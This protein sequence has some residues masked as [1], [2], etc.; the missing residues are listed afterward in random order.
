MVGDQNE[1][2]MI[3]SM[4]ASIT[5]RFTPPFLFCVTNLII[6]ILFMASKS[7]TKST[8]TTYHE[9]Q[10]HQEHDHE[11]EHVRG[12]VLLIKP[13][14]ARVTL[15]LERAKS[16]DLK[17]IIIPIIPIKLSSLPKLPKYTS[18]S[19]LAQ[20]IFSACSYDSQP[21]SPRY[22][23][24][25]LPK[26]L[27]PISGR[28][29]STDFSTIY[30]D[31]NVIVSTELQYISNSPLVHARVNSTKI[32]TPRKS[33]P[34]TL[35]DLD[36]HHVIRHNSE[37]TRKKKDMVEIIKTS[38]SEIRKLVW[39][40]DRVEIMKRPETARARQNAADDAKANDFITKFRGQLKLQ[41][42][43]SLNRYNDMLCRP[44]E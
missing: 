8:T 32:R 9:E 2:M 13:V 1:S 44:I 18:S 17:S 5:T 39:D 23:S 31:N 29:N 43:D 14:V 11:R 4:W 28:L 37:K 24:K 6:A 19:R 3:V 35:V 36:D 38:R 41:R 10:E 30:D 20:S 42:L 21:D 12:S 27:S 15:L 33:Q 25:K 7:N 34:S 16:I 26:P 22:P 40:D